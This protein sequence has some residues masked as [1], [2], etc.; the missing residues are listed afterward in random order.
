MISASLDGKKI[1]ITDALHFAGPGTCKG[2]VE[3]GAKVFAQDVGF[4][5]RAAREAFSSMNPDIGVIDASLAKDIAEQALL[6]LGRVDVLINNDAY[7]AP[8][9]PIDEAKPED[10][11]AALEHLVVR[12]FELTGRLVPQMKKRKSGKVIFL[13]SAGPLG[14]IPNYTIYAAARSAINGMIKS[15]SMELAPHGISVNA[16][17][18]N[19]LENPDYYPPELMAKPGVAEKILKRIPLGRLGEQEEAAA[20]IAFLAGEHS[21]FIT[22]QVIPFSG[23]WA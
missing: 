22:G 12:G 8:H 21:G 23:G 17:A 3:L 18:P 6:Q 14:G 1:L 15:L 7:P 19:Y 10:M 20:L 16:V 2:L 4:S 5:D 13:T 9:I 11:R